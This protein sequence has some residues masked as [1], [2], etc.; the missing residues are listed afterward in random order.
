MHELA[1]HGPA[2]TIGTSPSARNLLSAVLRLTKTLLQDPR[3]AQLLKWDFLADLTRSYGKKYTSPIIGKVWHTPAL[4]ASVTALKRSLIQNLEAGTSGDLRTLEG[5]LTCLNHLIH[6]SPHAAAFFFAGSDFLDGLIMCY[7]I[8]NP[9]LRQVII[10]TTYLCLIGLTVGPAPKFA[11][12]NDQLYAL[13]AAADLH[14]AGPINANDSL[15]PE[16]VTVTP[17]LKQTLHRAEAAG[18]ATAGLRSR[19]AALES[20]R[21]SG[22]TRRPKRLIRRKVDKGKGIAPGDDN[23]HDGVQLHVHR[24]SQIAQIQDLFPELGS[25]FVARLLDEYKENVEQVITHL[26]EDTLPPQL[27]NTDRT[28]KLYVQS[29]PS[30]ILFIPK[31]GK[32]RLTRSHFIGNTIDLVD[33]RMTRLL[34]R[35]LHPITTY[36]FG[37]TYMMMRSWIR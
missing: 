13:H 23:D 11:M 7:R 28:E 1:S 17:V 34:A 6:A 15:V 14:R 24:A 35:H 18:A 36:Q 31:S 26:L 12:L 10:A 33:A 9:P 4:Q 8:M 16:L 27:R 32:Q 21:K 29:L 19:I 20:Y 5:D 22:V 30:F 25:G 3:G 2:S 37:G